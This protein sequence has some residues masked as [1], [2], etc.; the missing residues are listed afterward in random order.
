MTRYYSMMFT[1][2][3]RLLASK[4]CLKD[5]FFF[6]FET[7]DIVTRKNEIIHCFGLK[8]ILISSCYCRG[9]FSIVRRCIHRESNQ[10]FAVKI[11]DV[12]KFTASPGLSTAGKLKQLTFI[13]CTN[14]HYF[15]SYTDWHAIN[16]IFG[17]YWF[18]N[19]VMD[20]CLFCTLYL[21]NFKFLR[22][23]GEYET[24]ELSIIVN[25]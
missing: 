4:Y 12:A 20:V 13:M 5:S 1:N 7:S 2:C 15:S 11:V 14:L 6:L 3:V 21:M 17:N 23:S 18:H 19:K 8:H 16:D 10:Q 25:Y 22:P 24:N 9:P